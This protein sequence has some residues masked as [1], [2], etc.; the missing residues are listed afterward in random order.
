MAENVDTEYNLEVEFGD[1][2]DESSFY[3]F[4][5][6][7]GDTRQESDGSDVDFEGIESNDED[8]SSEADDEQGNEQEQEWTDVLTDFQVPDFEMTTGINFPLP[9]VPKEIDFFS[10]FVGDDL[11]DLISLKLT[12]TPAKNCQPFPIVL[13][14][15]PKSHSRS[16]KHIVG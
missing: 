9:A 11:W 16:R 4:D 13:Q 5:E 3:G 15:S 6:G 8:S 14:S 10:A 7:E 1:S 12:S 2:G